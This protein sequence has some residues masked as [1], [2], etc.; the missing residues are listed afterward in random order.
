M[1]VFVYVFILSCFVLA[2]QGY[3]QTVTVMEENGWGVGN[4]LQD[5]MWYVNYEYT[6]QKSDMNLKLSFVNDPLILGGATHMSIDWGDGTPELVKKQINGTSY[7]HKYQQKDA[8]MVIKLYDNGG[9]VI[10]ILYRIIFNKSLEGKAIIKE[11]LLGNKFYIDGCMEDGIDTVLICLKDHLKNPPGTKYEVKV[12]NGIGYEIKYWDDN[13]RDTAY[14]IFKEP[15]GGPDDLGSSIDYSMKYI[16]PGEEKRPFVQKTVTASTESN[17]IQSVKV[18]AKPN[19]RKIFG[20]IDTIPV[21]PGKD[22]IINVCSGSAPDPSRIAYN[23]AVNQRYYDKKGYPDYRSFWDF[24]AQYYRK[25]SFAQL[26]WNELPSN[27]TAADTTRE[28]ENDL[29]FYESGLYRIRFEAHNT[30]GGDTLFTDSIPN[31]PDYVRYFKV[32]QSGEGNI[33]SFKD[34]SCLSGTTPVDTIVFVD[35]GKRLAL[36]FYPRYGFEIS[37]HLPGKDGKDSVF[38]SKLD[39]V[40]WGT[41]NVEFFEQKTYLGAQVLPNDRLDKSASDSVVLKLAFKKVGNYGIKLF[42]SSGTCDTVTY[43]DSLIVGMKPLFTN[44]NLLLADFGNNPQEQND[45]IDLCTKFTYKFPDNLGIDYRNMKP[46]LDS[47]VWLFKKGTQEDH[48]RPAGQY[49]FD[50][51]GDVRNYMQVVARNYCGDDTLSVDFYTR[52]LPKVSLWRDSVQNNDTLCLNFR[53]NYFFKD[54][55]PATYTIKASFSEDVDSAGLKKKEFILKNDSV[56]RGI[57]HVKQGATTETY[58]IK[59]SKNEACQQKLVQQNVLIVQPDSLY[60]KDTVFHCESFLDIN[61]KKLFNYAP[62][63]DSTFKNIEWTLNGGLIGTTPDNPWPDISLRGNDKDTLLVKISNSTGCYINQKLFFTPKPE[64]TWEVVPGKVTVT[65]DLYSMVSCA[66][67]TI[68]YK[69]LVKMNAEKA[70]SIV[71]T[72]KQREGK[73]EQMLYGMIGD[74]KRDVPLIVLTTTRAPF[75]I[76]YKLE[77]KKVT[78]GFGN[79]TKVDSIKVSVS[80]PRLN[81][82]FPDTLRDNT[83]NLYRFPGIYLKSKIDTAQVTIETNCWTPFNPMKGSFDSNN[84]LFGSVY[85]MHND[86]EKLDSLVFELKG[87][88]V[89]GDI[90]KDTLAVYIPVGKLFAHSDT[91]CEDADYRLWGA[92]RTWG[93]YIDTATLEWK[94]ADNKGGGTFVGGNEG[95]GASVCYL[96]VASDVDIDTI[97]IE[98]KGRVLFNDTEIRKDTIYLWVNPKPVATFPDTLFIGDGNEMIVSRIPVEKRKINNALNYEW[99][100]LGDSPGGTWEDPTNMNG[101]KFTWTRQIILSEVSVPIGIKMTG[102]KGCTNRGKGTY[103]DTMLVWRSKAPTWKFKHETLD[104]CKED[105]VR[106]DTSFEITDQV[107]SKGKIVLSWGTPA[108]VGKFNR[109]SSWYSWTA[110]MPE[111][112]SLS[113]SVNKRILLYTGDW[114]TILDTDP[115]NIPVKVYVEPTFT[116]NPKSDTICFSQTAV[117]LSNKIT[118]MPSAYQ[119]RLK[120]DRSVGLEGGYPNFT[121]NASTQEAK[122][123]ACVDQGG[124]K[125]WTNKTDTLHIVRLP[126]MEAGF[127]FAGDGKV[128]EN[129]EILIENIKKSSIAKKTY[130]SVQMNDGQSG[131]RV[132]EASGNTIF[133]PN[134]YHGGGGTVSFTVEPPLATCVNTDKVTVSKNIT[135]IGKPD[136]QLQK[137]DTTCKSEESYTINFTNHSSTKQIEWF[138]NDNAIPFV[139]TVPGTTTVSLTD[140]ITNSVEIPGK[141]ERLIK[142][143]AK[144]TPIEPCLDIV[145]ESL[146]LVL[147]DFPVITMPNALSQRCLGDTLILDFATINYSK[148]VQWASDKTGLFGNSNQLNTNYLPNEISGQHKLTLTAFGEHGCGQTMS[149]TTVEFKA[150]PKPNFIVSTVPVC[151]KSEILFTNT[152]TPDVSGTTWTWKTESLLGTQEDFKHTYAAAGT[153]DVRLQVKNGTCVRNITQS[154]IINP[155]PVPA[156]TVPDGG[157]LGINIP[158]NFYN[159]TTGANFYTWKFG[160]G[161]IYTNT[162][163]ATHTFRNPY[164][165]VGVNL[166]VTNEFHCVDSITHLVRVVDKPHVEFRIEVDSCKGDTRFVN[167]SSEDPSTKWAWTLGDGSFSQEKDPQLKY[168]ISNY[169]DTVYYVKLKVV[170]A[171]APDGITITDSVK[172][173]SNLKAILK[174]SGGVECQSPVDVYIHSGLSQGRADSYRINWGDGSPDWTKDTLPAKNI[175]HSYVNDTEDVHYYTVKLDVA[176]ACHVDAATLNVTIRPNVVQAAITADKTTICFGEEITFENLSKGFDNRDLQT[177][178]YFEEGKDPET[179]HGAS[180]F[181]KHVFHT[182]GKYEVRLRADDNCNGNTSVPVIIMVGGDRSLTFDAIG[183]FCSAQEMKMRVP[184]SLMQPARFFDYKWEFGDDSTNFKHVSSVTHKYVKEGNY[185]ATLTATAYGTTCKTSIDKAIRINRTPVARIA[186][187]SDVTGCAPLMIKLEGSGGLG[188]DDTWWDFGDGNQ[189]QRTEMIEHIYPKDGPYKVAF[190]IRSPEGC[191]DSSFVDI[192]VKPTPRPAFDLLS[193]RLFCTPDGRIKLDL[194]NTTP[195]MGESTYKWY[196]SAQPV[197]FSME[198]QPPIYATTGVF[199]ELE[200]KLVATNKESGCVSV[201]TDSI[202]SSHSVEAKLLINPDSVH[203]ACETVPVKFVSVSRYGNRL[204]WDLGDGSALQRDSVFVHA[205]DRP[206]EYEIKLKAENEYGCTDN[207]THI[208]TVYPLP[209][210]Q[211]IY[212]KDN[213]ILPED[214]LPQDIINNLPEVDN[215]GYLFTN[216]SSVAYY[217]FADNQRLYTKWD[218][219]D[220]ITT[221]DSPFHRFKNNGNYNVTLYATTMYGCIDSVSDNIK[222]GAVKGLFI[223]TAFAPADT[224]EEVNRFQPKGIGLSS[225][226]MQIY[227]MWGTCVWTSTKL[228][229]GR[230]AEYWDGTIDGAP[231][232]KATY[233]WKVSAIF[234]DGSVWNGKSG[235]LML[236][237]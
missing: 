205:Y 69:E 114:T 96:P 47:A 155:L 20:F 207:A 121:V 188:Q 105:S 30:C 112:T 216:Q 77:N 141:R 18:Y 199:G 85:R 191:M 6:P 64:P 104:L 26:A 162:L 99:I 66:P 180:Q 237:R 154:V 57:M 53:Y 167:L 186:K 157:I 160:D 10:K 144:I 214:G 108:N 196:Y 234:L 109:D 151:A 158:Y 48:T 125:K 230:P 103:I 68:P 176:N 220:T 40:G 149:T 35:R 1:K 124:C 135:V 193:D 192:L 42:R 32:A 3:G 203:N 21:D 161:S 223:P 118:V 88:T 224:R 41:E 22:I 97:K 129:G 147:W 137:H 140:L 4:T 198:I 100:S 211:F 225:Y 195:L 208:V 11:E 19:L 33:F 187:W 145:E 80:K 51:L 93:E 226:K 212:E 90:L 79:C 84:G 102:I 101:A 117:N 169:N 92:D 27:T 87:K 183:T 197:P 200:L 67:D 55:L 62:G 8:E 39:T 111:T 50:S 206:A 184:D 128:C 139:T 163:N 218:L 232:E 54:T 174:P 116:V 110:G 17:S 189:D 119:A 122:L 215:G 170:N 136:I 63:R 181:V 14:V 213:R 43:T 31:F 146:S 217:V 172:I 115:K 134:G 153:Y 89:C 222:V 221:E 15:N 229:N 143:K 138:V 46:G 127:D 58:V 177:Q 231:A 123:I 73:N 126:K 44:R 148:R 235:G 86:D 52:I 95:K 23:E 56:F 236:I 171:A 175:V 81:I 201:Y 65:G 113:L 25:D 28:A 76:Y 34:S 165:E 131:S 5:T 13:A 37:G 142:I 190:K 59:N 45:T 75:Y 202:V 83:S 164:T 182:P 159:E 98:V 194:R 82:L 130:W 70:D 185:I 166:I 168:K 107:K 227:D 94:I 2:K 12:N 38:I 60:Y 219:G 133:R 72:V 209:D 120:Y 173:I 29:K 7:S 74:S 210:V 24:K 179:H 233:I 78:P 156:F 16:K 91:I 150:V 152:S 178:W 9:S 228:D 49:D 204:S 106:V 71:L 61:S 36:D 132:D